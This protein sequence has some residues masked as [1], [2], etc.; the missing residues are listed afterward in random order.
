[1]GLDAVIRSAVATADSVTLS[2]QAQV[3]HYRYADATVDDSGKITWG[4]AHRVRCV[5][6]NNRVQGRDKEGRDVTS[7]VQ[8]TFPRPTVI[9]PLDRF[10]LPDGYSGSPI[11]RAGSVVDPS[12]N[13]EYIKECAI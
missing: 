8:L 11:Q 7:S 1:M 4:T 2:L 9:H 5:V 6:E 10:V 12:T 3:S 13:A